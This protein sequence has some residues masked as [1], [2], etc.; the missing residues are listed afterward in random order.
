MK[1]RIN[2]ER[3]S[4]VALAA[5]SVNPECFLIKVTSNITIM[6]TDRENENIMIRL[7]RLLCEGKLNLIHSCFSNKKCQISFQQIAVI[8]SCITHFIGLLHLIVIR[9]SIVFFSFLDSFLLFFLCLHG[10][11]LHRSL[12]SLIQNLSQYS[13]HLSYLFPSTFFFL[14]FLFL[15]LNSFIFF[16][17]FF[18]S[19]FS[20][21]FFEFDFHWFTL[22]HQQTATTGTK[23]QKKFR[24]ILLPS[25]FIHS[26]D[27]KTE[28]KPE[29]RTLCIARVFQFTFHDLRQP[30]LKK[31]LS[32][33]ASI[34]NKSISFPTRPNTSLFPHNRLILKQDIDFLLTLYFITLYLN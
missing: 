2:K 6:I 33:F 12:L 34:F 16:H 19:Y 10:F 15:F 22:I 4:L 18:L 5:R 27:C 7:R 1:K 25:N 23:L 28:N 9:F 8:P 14:T 24:P 26:F 3:I 31:A 21:I 32:I 30:F 13:L 29:L 17:V 20:F 11:I